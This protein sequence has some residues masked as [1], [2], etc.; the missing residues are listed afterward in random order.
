MSSNVKT[1][2]KLEN[3]IRSF[4]ANLHERTSYDFQTIVKVNDKKNNVL[5]LGK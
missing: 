2:R 3:I 5:D 1:R 4:N